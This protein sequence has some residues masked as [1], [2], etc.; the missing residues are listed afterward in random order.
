MT[1]KVHNPIP[2]EASQPSLGV[3]SLACFCAWA[4]ISRGQTYLE[5][6]AGRL[7]PKHIGRRV[8]VPREEAER[9]LRDL[10]DWTGKT[11]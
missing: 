5:I 3:F 1:A 11:V 10:P 6:K 8:V 7:T 9:W 2:S 4:G